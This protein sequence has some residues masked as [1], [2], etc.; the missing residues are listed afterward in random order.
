MRHLAAS[1]L[2]LSLAASGSLT[3]P[4]NFGT[5]P[6]D[7]I[8]PSTY[9]QELV[10]LTRPAPATRFPTVEGHF[11]GLERDLVSMFAEEIDVPLRVI[12][13][14]GYADALAR[15]QR[16]EAHL[17]A[18]GL[19]A[20][21]GRDE[22]IVFGP[23]YMTVRQVLVHRAGS[24]APR[25]V[26]ALGDKRVVVA[27][28]SAG[29]ERFERAL[30]KAPEVNVEVVTANAPEAVTA[31][32]RA[33]NAEYAVMGSHMFDLLRVAFPQ[34][35][36]AMTLGEPDKL[37][38]AFPADADPRLLKQ[39]RRFFTRIQSNGTLPRLIDR[40]YGHVNRL[41][42]LERETFLERC[43][44]SLSQYRHAFIAAQNATG[45]D[46]RLIA[47]LG[48][49]ESKWDPLATSPTGVR[50]FMMLTDQTAARTGLRDKLHARS[51]ILAGARYLKSLRDALPPRIAE[52]DRT[53]LALAAYN[54]GPGHLEDARVLAQRNG[55]NPDVWLDV[56]RALPLLA[57]AEYNGD[58]R[59]GYARGGEAM[60]L[61]ENVRAYYQMLMQIEPAIGPDVPL[62]TPADGEPAVTSAPEFGFLI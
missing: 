13:A 9:R 20:T 23:G 58:L 2:L 17:A 61:T 41:S 22:N 60:A 33:G 31:T 14:S 59:H 8:D 28:Q 25:S 56:K 34:Y 11:A 36:R 39:A 32:L 15:L 43:E 42:Q 44:T 30:S 49:Q 38:W 6:A 1:T 26:R 19:T 10:V 16:G 18:A 29:A 12:E 47:A 62:R 7:R 48:Y 4:A 5:P 3:I 50:G 40:Y 45:I 55:G 24:E 21:R 53:W 52:P 37:A 57:D 27:A 46:W 51:S 54:Q 35:R